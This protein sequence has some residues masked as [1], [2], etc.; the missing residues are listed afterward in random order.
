MVSE[1]S[2]GLERNV[3][4]FVVNVEG[5]SRERSGRRCLVE[6]L[7]SKLCAART[8][9]SLARRWGLSSPQE[10]VSLSTTARADAPH[11]KR[12]AGRV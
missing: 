1:R 8:Y 3:S 12:N 4:F 7:S 5:V 2:V 10:V 9:L 6:A 11:K